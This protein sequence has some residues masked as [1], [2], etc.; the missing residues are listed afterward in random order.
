M[1]A[2]GPMR[3]WTVEIGDD[4]SWVRWNRWARDE[5]DARKAAMA[6]ARLAFATIT[7]ANGKVARMPRDA[8]IRSCSERGP[9]FIW[10]IDLREPFLSAAGRSVA[11]WEPTA[12]WTL[13]D[14]VAAAA[15]IAKLA[16]VRSW[17][18]GIREIRVPIGARQVSRS[19]GSAMFDLGLLAEG[20]N[21]THQYALTSVTRP[22]M[23][24]TAIAAST[25]SDVEYSH[26]ARMDVP[27]SA[28]L[29]AMLIAQLAETAAKNEGVA[30]SILKKVSKRPR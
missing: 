27:E 3:H 19:N 28:T 2:P 9:G 17:T 20:P 8:Q 22:A 13:D 23:L 16:A 10:S 11:T 21:G 25:A 30:L 4:R 29:K 7:T 18:Q 15:A 1:D 14:C 12:P 6:D 5:A 24:A 26:L